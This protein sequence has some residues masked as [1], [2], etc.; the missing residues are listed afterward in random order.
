MNK[1]VFCPQ[2]RTRDTFEREPKKDVCGIE[3]G[4]TLWEAWI[5]KL[6]GYKAVNQIKEVNSG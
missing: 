4:K 2:C 6:C 1:L 3:S 5:C